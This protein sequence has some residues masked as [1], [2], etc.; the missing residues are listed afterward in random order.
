MA[1]NKYKLLV[2]DIDGTLENEA[3]EISGEDRAALMGIRECGIQVAVSTGRITTAC[4]GIF[5]QLSLEGC[6]IFCDGALVSDI[7]GSNSIYQQS[8]DDEIVQETIEFALSHDL[9]L[10]L[11]TG[12]EYFVERITEATRIHCKLLNM[13]PQVADFTKLKG[14]SGFIK[15]NLVKVGPEEEAGISAFWEKF[16]GRVSLARVAMPR[17]PNVE[18]INV[19]ARDV[20]KGKATKKLAQHMGVTMEEVVALGD[21]MNDISVIAIAGLGIAMGS[22]PEELKKTA[23][24]VT[25]DAAHSGV[26]YALKKFLLD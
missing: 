1:Q 23:D 4:R 13:K 21:G 16:T 8:L 7:T 15:E 17:F 25:L 11:A 19:V 26:A 22:A 20:S 10:E 5:E 3:G 2:T 12:T 9:Y 14:R 18:F 6:H 24:Y